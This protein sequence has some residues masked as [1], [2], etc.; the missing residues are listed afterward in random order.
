MH[1]QILGLYTVSDAKLIQSRSFLL[2]SYKQQHPVAITVVILPGGRE[3][4]RS[5]VRKGS[6]GD[7]CVGP[8][9]GVKPLGN[10]W[11]L[12]ARHVHCDRPH[13][14]HV[15]YVDRTIGSLGGGAIIALTDLGRLKAPISPKPASDHC[16]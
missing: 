15:G 16:M 1:N 13:A 3:L 5:F 4:P 8:V 11:R 7:G 9:R 14:R 10:C 12:Q 6:P 2:A